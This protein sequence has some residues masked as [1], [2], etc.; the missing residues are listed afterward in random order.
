MHGT[1][2]GPYSKE[3]AH[4]FR[5]RNA[6]AFQ[7]C[8]EQLIIDAKE[9]KRNACKA[10]SSLGHASIAVGLVT[11]HLSSFAKDQGTAR[12]QC[13]CLCLSHIDGQTKEMQPSRSSQ[14]D[15]KFFL[16]AR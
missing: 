6:I 16:K 2:G 1:V 8:F 12:V 9:C 3:P 11:E 7:Q 4:S 15:W 5:F 14:N 13:L 10:V